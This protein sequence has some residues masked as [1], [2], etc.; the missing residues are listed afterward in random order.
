MSYVKRTVVDVDVADVQ[1][2]KKPTKTYVSDG[3]KGCSPCTS[4][5]T[6]SR[7]CHKPYHIVWKWRLCVVLQKFPNIFS[8]LFNFFPKY[9][10][11][12]LPSSVVQ[13]YVLNVKWSEGTKFSIYRNYSMLIEFQ[14][15]VVPRP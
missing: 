6:L 9:L 5:L 8:I 12:C 7:H 1:K 11:R 10:R 3:V 2:R 4:D 15:S 13:V 14:V